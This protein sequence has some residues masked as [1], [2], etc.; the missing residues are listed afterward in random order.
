MGLGEWQWIIIYLGG[1]SNCSSYTICG[2]LFQQINIFSGN[3]DAVISLSNDFFSISSHKAY[4]KQFPLS[5]KASNTL[6]FF[7]LKGI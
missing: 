3:W 4:Y 7:Y 2:L 5:G 6:S 1:L